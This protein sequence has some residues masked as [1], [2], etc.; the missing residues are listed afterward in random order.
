MQNQ[1]PKNHAGVS[2]ARSR[3][4][5]NKDFMLSSSILQPNKRQLCS[6]LVHIYMDLHNSRLP[7]GILLFL[8]YLALTQNEEN[9]CDGIDFIILNAKATPIHCCTELWLT[10]F[11]WI[12][13]FLL[14]SEKGICKWN[15]KGTRMIMKALE[16]VSFWGISY[17][18]HD[19]NLF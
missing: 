7:L 10:E 11:W 13:I 16:A 4:S 15:Q 17:D 12:S 2:T 14:L 18:V 9:I 8:C 3:L 1:S 5:L 19:Y 6:T